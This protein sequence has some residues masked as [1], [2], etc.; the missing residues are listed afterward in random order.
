MAFLRDYYAISNYSQQKGGVMKKLAVVLKSKLIDR[1]VTGV[2]M[3][4]LLTAIFDI[5]LSACCTSGG[6][7]NQ[8]NKYPE[9][10]QA[11]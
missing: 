9:V 3:I 1:G 4:A 6:L 10:Q 5:D 8:P 7:C 11:I 2:V